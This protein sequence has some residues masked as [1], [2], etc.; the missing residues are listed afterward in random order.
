MTDAPTANDMMSAYA[1]DAVDY[2]QQAFGLPLD[3]SEESIKSIEEVLTRLHASLPRGFLSRLFKRGPSPE[4]ID[5]ICKMLGGYVGEVM[6]RHWG[7]AWKLGSDVA[8]G[9]V[10]VTLELP[11]GT[12]VWPQFKVAKR[13][14]NGPEDN[15]WSYFRVLK[16]RIGAEA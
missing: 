6:R 1:S 9:Q 4:Q 2:C 13:L 14:S 8:P 10:I 16:D 3:F 7:G 5:T 12:D 11:G 15:V